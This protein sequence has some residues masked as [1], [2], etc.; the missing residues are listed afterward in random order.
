[1]GEEPFLLPLFEPLSG[2]R[3]MFRRNDVTIQIPVVVGVRVPVPVCR[4]IVVEGVVGI[5]LVTA[6][7][8]S[9]QIA[10][11]RTLGFGS[12]AIRRIFIREFLLVS[13]G[14]TA[15]GLVVGLLVGLLAVGSTSVPVVPVAVCG[16]VIPPGLAFLSLRRFSAAPLHD[17]LAELCL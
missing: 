8:R 4:Q 5:A 9:D 6:E 15:A 14:A 13:A 10:L 3:K 11:L 16:T 7:T 17:Q 12:S 1:M 2:F